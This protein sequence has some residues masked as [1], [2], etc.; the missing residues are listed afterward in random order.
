MSQIIKSIINK[1][2]S[3]AGDDADPREHARL[4]RPGGVFRTGQ[5]NH[6]QD[7]RDQRQ[8]RQA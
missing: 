2:K 1:H 4:R 8:R 5:P 3:G 6:A 7:Q